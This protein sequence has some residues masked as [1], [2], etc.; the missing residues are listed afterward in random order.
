MQPRNSVNL[1]TAVLPLA[2]FTVALTVGIAYFAGDNGNDGDQPAGSATDVSFDSSAPHY[3]PGSPAEK[4]MQAGSS[5]SSI[6]LFKSVNKDYSSG[7]GFSSKSEKGS[8]A[9][10][11]RTRAE[12]NEFMK[13]L[14]ADIN[15]DPA[16]RA[17][18][19]AAVQGGGGSGGYSGGAGMLANLGHEQR[20]GSTSVKTRKSGG[21]PSRNASSLN[22]GKSSFS[23]GG[24]RASFFRSGGSSGK[25]G[26][27][28]ASFG[29]SETGTPNSVTGQTLVSGGGRSLSAGAY[30][31]H[32]G[33]SGAS[34]GLAD[35]SAAGG[36]GGGYG[37]SAETA[38]MMGGG[39]P[40]QEKPPPAPIAFV[41]PRSIDFGTMYMYETAV[42]QIIVMNIGQLPL[43][44]HGK[45][46]NLDDRTPFYVEGDKCSN[47]TVKPGKSCTFRL[48][49]SPRNKKEY[50]TGFEIPTNDNRSMVYQSYIEVKGVSKYSHYTWWWNRWNRTGGSANRLEFGLVPAGWSMGQEL[51]IT[52]SSGRAWYDIK[53]DKSALP[54]CFAISSDGCSGKHL[55]SRQ[56]CSVKVLFRPTDTANRG[57]SNGHYGQYHAVDFE[58][59][60]KLYHSRPK[61]P[62]Y[63]IEKPVEVTVKGKLKV[64]A[65]YNEE[66]YHT[67]YRDVLSVP[68]SAR[69]S[70]RFPVKGLV[71]VQHYFYFE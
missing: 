71:R 12:L 31:S 2:A 20:A 57:F 27:V 56:T 5:G 21:G 28:G 55:G 25:Q 14:R 46:S 48:R 1:K 63:V 47:R 15:M 29:N 17:A 66:H 19:E 59:A 61:F 40:Q 52:N 41:W 49:F 65:K 8:A 69:S 44:I 64:R 68:V 32:G 16:E 4:R 50:L 18:A 6:D 53:L 13:Q 26:S 37:A 39:A 33:R 67:N 23:S 9:G 70:A 60:K 22:S 62:P 7:S 35:G 24:A 54:S 10:K 51:K 11:P 42:R 34:G 3:A 43:K 58:T 36:A 45:I 38:A 30:G